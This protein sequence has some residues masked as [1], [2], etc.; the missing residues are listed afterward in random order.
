MKIPPADD[1]YSIV[2]MMEKVD[3]QADPKFWSCLKNIHQITVIDYYVVF[4]KSRMER[5]ITSYNKDCFKYKL[6]VMSQWRLTV[7][8]P[9]N[10]L[11]NIYAPIAKWKIH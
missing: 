7:P 8:A 6:H 2:V 5:N 4:L 9:V 1:T 10:Y 11:R 3:R